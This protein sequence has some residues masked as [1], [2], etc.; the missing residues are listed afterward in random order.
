MT[1]CH[2]GELTV[3][4]K[5][6]FSLKSK[7]KWNKKPPPPLAFAHIWMWALGRCAC[8]CGWAYGTVRTPSHMRA[9]M[10]GTEM[11]PETLA[12]F[13]VLTWLIVW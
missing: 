11:V 8:M 1:K 3:E 6:N 7:R 13:N 4:C 10:I 2:L 12:V 5:Q 9:L